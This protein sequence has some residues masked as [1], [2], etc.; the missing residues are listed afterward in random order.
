MDPTAVAAPVVLID[1]PVRTL[2]MQIEEARK[3]SAP[4]RFRWE[5]VR[6]FRDYARG[7][8]RDTLSPE[9]RRMLRGVRTYR[10]V[11]NIAHK[12]IFELTNRVQLLRWRVPD[13]TVQ[14]HLDE[15]WV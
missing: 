1:D 3:E 7:R 9:Q 14:D 12:V 10:V 8:Q 15:L 11:D 13:E 2:H 5:D 4:S 6:A